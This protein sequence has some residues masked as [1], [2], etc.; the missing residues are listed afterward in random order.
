MAI[1]NIVVADATTPT[2]VN[3]TFVPIADGNEARYVNDAGSQTLAGQET[4]GFNVKRA[5]DGKSA[6]VVR[7]TMWDP[8][9]V[10][11][12]SGTYLVDHGNSAD[13]RFNFAQNATL[14]ERLN[15]VTMHI[16]ALTAMKSAISGLQPQL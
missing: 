6:N 15:T 3:H 7:M 4:I 13:T 8:T 12:P 2:P 5:T 11:G 14:Q 10:Q 9:E 16:N 1:A